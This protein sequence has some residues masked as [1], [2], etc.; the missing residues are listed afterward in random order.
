L[1]DGEVY[2]QKNSGIIVCTGTGS[3]SWHYNIN[4]LTEQNFTD[5]LQK[6]HDLGYRVKPPLNSN[7]IEELCQRYNER[8]IF[9]P[10]EKSKLFV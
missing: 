2:K 6:M 5:V 3:T 8:L 10:D 1:D 9:A 7:G 4:R